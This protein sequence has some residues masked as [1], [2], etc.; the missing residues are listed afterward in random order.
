M[1]IHIPVLLL[2][3]SLFLSFSEN[4]RCQW[5]PTNGHL[6][7]ITSLSANGANLYAGTMFGGAVFLT[8]DNGANWTTIGNTI[9]GSI[10][11]TDI[12]S[13]VVSG[14]NLFAGT[15]D[16]IF[17]TTNTGKNWNAV[18]TGLPSNTIVQ[19]FAVAPAASTSNLFA[20][21]SSGVI[22][23]TNNGKNW[24]PVNTG[25]THLDV[26][27]FAVSGTSLFA[28][29]Y[30]GGV[31]LSTDSGAHWTAINS[32]LTDT[33]IVAMAAIGT[34][35]FVGSY[36]WPYAGGVFLSTNNGTSWAKVTFGLPSTG[37]YNLELAVSGTNLFAGNDSGVYLS[38]NNGTNWRPENTG[39]TNAYAA[40]GLAVIGTNIFAATYDTVWRRPLLEMIPTNAVNA[41]PDAEHSITA[42]PNPL[43]QSTTVTFSSPES[44]QA[45]VTIVNLLGTEVARI[46]SGE[47]GA[48]EHSFTW[49]ARG[50]P[51]GMYECLVRMNGHAHEIPV[52]LAR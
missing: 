3:A 9:S 26:R 8:T 29:T 39:L 44:G 50:M 41:W 4:T 6:G 33:N 35:I 42:Y 38:T 5:I 22:F 45:E 23:S 34:N 46:F 13:L 28:G 37:Y 18:N 7:S 10:G 40:Q 1:K 17:R 43:K 25:L 36:V 48:G 32:G 16:G 11:A 47:L 24:K 31:F 2:V 30:G 51:P 19:A 27:A 21:T 20:G 52:M 12:H 15:A 14:T 49:D